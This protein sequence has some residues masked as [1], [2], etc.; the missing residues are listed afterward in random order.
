MGIFGVYALICTFL[1]LVYY[2]VTIW[3]DLHGNKGSRKEETETIATGDM[4][5]TETS[6]DVRELDGGGYQLSSSDFEDESMEVLVQ[7]EP[8]VEPSIEPA[9]TNPE[10]ITDPVVEK[11]V[12]D[13]DSSEGPS[14]YERAKKV[15]DE[16]CQQP[17]KI[18][19][20]QLMGV[21][22]LAKMTIPISQKNEVHRHRSRC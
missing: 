1:L 10:P 12:N 3:F 15:H 9:V 20:M 18:Y 11:K 4:V 7:E 13:E 6:T 2:M 22:M 19:E 5:D 14:E 16:S 17:N 21:G 8:S